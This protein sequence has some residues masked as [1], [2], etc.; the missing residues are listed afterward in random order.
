M[1]MTKVKLCRDC[2]H[3]MPEPGSEWVLRCTHP[4]VNGQ[5]PW[6]LASSKPH[7]SSTYDERKKGNWFSA[8]GM[9]GALWEPLVALQTAEEDDIL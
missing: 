3:H 8:C 2:K 1:K 6:A 9:R 4:G 5:D 7:G